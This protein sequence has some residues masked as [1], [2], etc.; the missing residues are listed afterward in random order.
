MFSPIAAP[1]YSTALEA[2]TACESDFELF[3]QQVYETHDR[4][5]ED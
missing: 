1:G 5:S 2:L 4:E 3:S